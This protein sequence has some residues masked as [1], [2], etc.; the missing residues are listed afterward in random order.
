MLAIAGLFS[1]LTCVTA[2]EID[3]A[4]V[5]LGRDLFHD[6]RLSASQSISCS[7]CHDL[8]HAGVDPRGRSIGT[9]GKPLNRDTPSVYNAVLDF[10]QLRDGRVRTLDELVAAAMVNPQ[11]MGGSWEVTTERLRQDQPLAAR[12]ITIY[13]EPPT[14]TSI[15]SALTTFLSTL[16]TF[17][18]PYDRYQQ[19]DRRALTPEALQ[20][21]ALF[22]QLGCIRCHDGENLGGNQ[23]QHSRLFFRFGSNED[24]LQHDELGNL[25]I[26]IEGGQPGYD[27]HE[28]NHDDLMEADKGRYAITHQNRDR[29]T[30][31]VPNLRNVALTAPYFH[32][33]SAETLKEAIFEM[34]EHQLGLILNPQQIEQ[35]A[36]FLHALSSDR[37]RSRQPS[38]TTVERTQP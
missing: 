24:L 14:Q 28:G 29:H 9:D 38:A 16:V 17:D 15:V 8:D 5:A 33:S 2:A 25:S 21:L 3:P 32:D 11:L 4:E 10:R 20:G 12:F 18:T 35:M 34:A 6:P 19:G 1:L 7:S 22:R 23:F 13:G 30:F 31:K 36:Q 27:K 26:P 37:L